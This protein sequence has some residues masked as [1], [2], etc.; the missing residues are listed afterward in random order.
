MALRVSDY[1]RMVRRMQS[2]T[3][4]KV[5]EIMK[6]ARQVQAEHSK[7][8]KAGPGFTRPTAKAPTYT[9]KTAPGAPRTRR[10]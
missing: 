6:F 7:A 5:S 2:K 3:P 1:M 8:G 9:R 10:K 4:P